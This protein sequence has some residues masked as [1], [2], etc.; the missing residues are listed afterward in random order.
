M[1]I[2]KNTIAASKTDVCGYELMEKKFFHPQMILHPINVAPD[3]ERMI[4]HVG[5]G[6]LSENIKWS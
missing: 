2:V 1:P 4:C 5:R 3:V 6:H